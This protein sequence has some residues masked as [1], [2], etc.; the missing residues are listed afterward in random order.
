MNV[1]DNMTDLG[2]KTWQA[3]MHTD[4]ATYANSAMQVEIKELRAALELSRSECLEQARLLGMGGEREAK[5]MFQVDK[6]TRE[7]NVR[8]QESLTDRC[9]DLS[10]KLFEL[11]GDFKG[12]HAS[13]I[14]SMSSLL[15]IYSH[16]LE[17][18]GKIAAAKSSG[19]VYSIEDQY[20]NVID[21]LPEPVHHIMFDGK[22]IG[23]FSKEQMIQ[24]RVDSIRQC[25][26]IMESPNNNYAKVILNKMG[27]INLQESKEVPNSYE[28]SKNLFTPHVVKGQ[29]NERYI[30]YIHSKDVA[31]LG[32]VMISATPDGPIFEAK[33]ERDRCGSGCYCGSFVTPKTSE[34]VALLATAKRL[35]D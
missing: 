30:T 17:A 11:A 18:G 1:K 6:L 28:S 21:E 32:S 5:L 8:N 34:G 14:I 9:V 15:K 10:D 35:I 24:L 3:K 29:T 2:I 27:L 25:A 22:C 33:Y 16:Q 7:S 23:F 20:A 13:Q 12:G 26:K 31:D 4:D 19:E